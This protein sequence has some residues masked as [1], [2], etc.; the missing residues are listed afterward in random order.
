[1]NELKRVILNVIM[2]KAD[3]LSR[4]YRYRRRIVLLRDVRVPFSRT[5]AHIL[6]TLEMILDDLWECIVHR[7]M[8]EEP[9]DWDE[10]TQSSILEKK[11]AAG[12]LN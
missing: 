3:Q 9:E 8:E 12:D 6:Y 5:R 7:L 10:I 4:Y 2:R 11:L 1:M